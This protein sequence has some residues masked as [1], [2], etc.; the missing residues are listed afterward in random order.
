MAAPL[1]ALP[2]L[3]KAVGFAK[4]LTGLG[5]IAKGSA[6]IA[7]FAKGAAAKRA[8]GQKLASLFGNAKTAAKGFSPS[9]LKNIEFAKKHY[10]MDLGKTTKEMLNSGLN[11]S[12]DAGI[13]DRIKRGT[14]SFEG[15]GKNLGIPLDSKDLVMSFAPDAAFGL[16]AGAMT[17]GDLGDKAIAATGATLGGAAGGLTARGILGP[18]GD[19]TRIATELGGGMMGDAVGM[20]IA[21]SLIAAKNGGMTPAEASYREQEAAVRNA[22]KQDIYRELGLM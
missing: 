18:K 22:M 14:T 8:A 2:M 10:G 9:E 15:F 3:G 6:G 21:N 20:N 12:D 1:L 5:G 7:G 4:G 19:L 13:L 11:M 17:E 16:I